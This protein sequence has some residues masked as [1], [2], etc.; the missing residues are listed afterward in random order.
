MLR[1]A[2]L[3]LFAFAAPAMAATSAANRPLHASLVITGVSWRTPVARQAAQRQ[4]PAPALQPRVTI[5][6]AGEQ[7][8]KL[9]YY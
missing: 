4:F 5:E 9:I 6:R 2:A 8:V 1:A 7:F 3:V